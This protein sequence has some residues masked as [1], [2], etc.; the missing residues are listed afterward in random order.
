MIIVWYENH[1]VWRIVLL[2]IYCVL[3]VAALISYGS[4]WCFHTYTLYRKITTYQYL[5]RN[6]KS[7]TNDNGS[8]NKLSEEYKSAIEKRNKLERQQWES[9]HSNLNSNNTKSESNINVNNEEKTVDTL[10]TNNTTTTQSTGDIII[11]IKDKVDNNGSNNGSSNNLEVKKDTEP[12][13]NQTSPEV[14]IEIN[15]VK[16]DSTAETQSPESSKVEQ[17]APAQQQQEKEKKQFHS[18]ANSPIKNSVDEEKIDINENDIELKQK[19][20]EKDEGIPATIVEENK[21]EVSESK[22]ETKEETNKPQ[23]EKKD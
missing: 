17:P 10:A 4:L 22:E 13:T 7:Y 5:N 14:V 1:K 11:N 19:E 18:T 9:Q 21:K 12:K 23:E 15:E 6:R 8:N 3:P 20:N 2:S 16:N